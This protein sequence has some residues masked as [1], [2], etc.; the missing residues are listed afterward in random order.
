M[1]IDL[2]LVR[3]KPGL[4]TRR[5]N[6]QPLIFDIIRR[7]W[8]AAQPEELV[9]QLLVAYLIEEKGYNRNRISL[10]Q[11]LVVNE[12]NK[13][14]DILVYDAGMRPY[15]LVECK[16]PQVEVTNATFRQIAQYN[17]PLGVAY[18]LVSNGFD[19]YCCEMDYEARTFHFLDDVPG[20]PG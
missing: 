9:R 10:E 11:S 15:L 17:L 12:L 6:N 3:F 2:H 18:Q 16:A 14:C 1:L 5:E 7:K 8:L 19:S 20:P 13:R 4:Q